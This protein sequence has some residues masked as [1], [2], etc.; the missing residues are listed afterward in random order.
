MEVC[1]LR[2]VEDPRTSIWRI[3]VAGINGVPLVWRILREQ[4]LYLYQIQWVEALIPPDHRARVVFCQWLPA[5]CILN[6]QFLA[7]ILFTDEVRFIREDAVNFRNTHVRVGESPHTN[8]ILRHQHW[9]PISVSV[10]MLG[11]VCHQFLMNDL[12]VLLEH[13]PLYQR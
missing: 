8:V 5:K 12:L 7:N 4:L 9:F 3:V 1:I 11:A 6:T 2:R 13:A 10:G